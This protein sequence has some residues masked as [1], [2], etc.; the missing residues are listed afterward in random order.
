MCKGNVG[1]A[2]QG[3]NVL[4]HETCFRE[5]SPLTGIRLPLRKTIV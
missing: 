5:T 1:M 3:W 4:M 2:G